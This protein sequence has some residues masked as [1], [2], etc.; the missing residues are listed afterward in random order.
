MRSRML[1]SKYTEEKM[2]RFAGLSLICLT[3]L[4]AHASSEFTGSSWSLQM[5]QNNEEP[6]QVQTERKEYDKTGITLHRRTKGI[7]ENGV[8]KPIYEQGRGDSFRREPQDIDSLLKLS[9]Q[10]ESKRNEFKKHKRKMKHCPD[11][12]FGSKRKKHWPFAKHP[13]RR[14]E[15]RHDMDVREDLNENFADIEPGAGHYAHE[16]SDFGNIENRPEGRHHLR[17]HF[18][19]H[20]P[21]NLMK[22]RPH[23]R[24]V[25]FAE[26]Q[27]HYVMIVDS[28]SDVMKDRLKNRS[29]VSFY[30]PVEK[31]FEKIFGIKKKDSEKPDVFEKDL[32]MQE[33]VKPN[34][35]KKFS[36]ENFLKRNNWFKDFDDRQSLAGTEELLKNMKEFEDEFFNEYY[37]VEE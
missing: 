17:R 30:R 33:P 36:R 5:S 3:F 14:Y 37:D 23:P 7:I 29:R 20:G 22:M 35:P 15:E 9:D 26:G 18:R 16:N 27:P 21:L 2:N 28:N 10:Y 12:F 6:I 25:E 24:S 32:R 4:S 11:E 1:I 34:P 19:K 8:Y 31:M 13:P